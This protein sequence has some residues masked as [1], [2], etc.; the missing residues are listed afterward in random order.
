MFW[1]KTT[2]PGFAPKSTGNLPIFEPINAL[3]IVPAWISAFKRAPSAWEIIIT[4]IVTLP[5]LVPAPGTI[6]AVATL[7]IITT[8]IAP[9]VWAANALSPNSH[10]PL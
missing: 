6:G 8:P 1:A 3:V 4:G 7:L 9:A 2:S 10:A 5:P